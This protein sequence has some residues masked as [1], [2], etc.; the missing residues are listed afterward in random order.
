M[1][2]KDTKRY[3]LFYYLLSLHSYGYQQ[4]SPKNQQTKLVVSQLL[5]Q[6]AC[7]KLIAFCNGEVHQTIVDHHY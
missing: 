5:D 2:I 7:Q 6:T 1:T 3:T 4:S